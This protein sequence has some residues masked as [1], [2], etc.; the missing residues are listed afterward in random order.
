MGSNISACPEMRL[1]PWS[2]MAALTGWY[3]GRPNLT[4]RSLYNPSALPQVDFVNGI[5]VHN[6]AE[7]FAREQEGRRASKDFAI[8]IPDDRKGQFV[9]HAATRTNSEHKVKPSCVWELFFFVAFFATSGT[10]PCCGVDL[11]T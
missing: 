1:H 7:Q 3:F 9:S 4:V 8:A 10:T 6:Y 11:M 2:L 5:D